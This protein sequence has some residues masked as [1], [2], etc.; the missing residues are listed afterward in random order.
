M[1]QYREPQSRLQLVI[2]GERGK[3]EAFLE[4]R[5]GD[6]NKSQV[7]ELWDENG[8]AFVYLFS[9]SGHGPSFKIPSIVLS[10]SQ[11]L[12]NLIHGE[13][14]SGRRRGKSFDGRG[15][16]SVEDATRNLAIRGPGT[17]P[18]TPKSNIIDNQSTSDGSAESIRSFAD[19]S[20]EIHLYFPIPLTTTGPQ[21][22]QQDVQAL[23]EV[24]NLFAFLT[25]QPLVG[26]RAYPTH[27]RIVLAVA[28][29][30]KRFEFTNFDGSTYGEAAT[31]S[32]NFFLDDLRLADVSQ[33]REKT[34]EG[35]ILGERMRSTELYN[36]C[37]AHAVGKYDA[38]KGIRSPLFNEISSNTRARLE[39]AYLDLQQRQKSVDLRLINFDFP[40]LFA[41]IAASTSSEESKFV[42]FKA[43]RSN[44]MS[45]RKLIMSYYKD[46]HGQ[47]PPKASSKKNN[48]VEGGLNRLVLKGLYADLCSLYDLLADRESLTTRSYDAP[49]DN[50]DTSTVD[51]TAA[52]LRRLLSEY[53]RS[54]P[55]VQPPIP[56]DIPRV[57]TMAT[58]EPNYPFLGPREQNVSS[59]RKLKDYE[60]KLLIAKSH[61]LFAD[62][63]TPFLEMYRAFEEKEARGK[64]CTELADQ[65]YG[66]W[67][68][69]YAVIQSLPMLVVDA[70][71]LRFTQGVEYFLCEP[72]MGNAPWIEDAG[73]VKMSWYG[74]Q[75]GQGV[76]S[77]PSDIVN[78]GVEGI[79]RR[80]HCW[81]VAETW[82]SGGEADA[83]VPPIGDPLA[84]GEMLSPL[85]PPP[86][87]D[88]DL[89]LRPATSEA[90]GRRGRPGSSSGPGPATGRI[91]GVNLSPHGSSGDERRSRS[92]QSQR[93]SIAL[94]LER[95]PIPDGHEAWNPT[96]SQEYRA[97]SPSAPY[98]GRRNS[99]M[100][101]SDGAGAIVGGGNSQEGS[102]KGSTFDDILGSL[103]QSAGGKGKKR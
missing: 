86:G 12:I 6:A 72:P 80:S 75:G 5:K 68:F 60:T 28:S 53:D 29:L 32:F 11:P 33:S 74:I 18:Y 93:N 43:W 54:S 38:V 42:N 47:W 35:I 61:N 27:F 7:P 64:N 70:P 102:R 92:R 50:E 46:L 40:S 89:N 30:L 23:V 84:G 100:G 37:F 65:R 14:H 17:P 9:R 77:L 41:G 4:H 62:Y 63:K 1:G 58:V 31:A 44:F 78:Y 101:G 69:L 98:G 8:D 79:Y 21:L 73:Q 3:G 34:I 59:I 36:E 90:R 87:F 2:V 97:S 24:R 94:G 66:H 56:F 10:S 26:T 67:I 103:D 85:A 49:S 76:V 96:S 83:H 57:P 88:G 15:S 91:D 55:P 48:F 20:R 95:L 13:I 52:A 99:S 51:K 45:M 71:N 81:T 82:I 16:L 39:R 22:S 19:A 25:G